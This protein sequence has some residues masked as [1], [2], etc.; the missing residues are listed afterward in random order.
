M[1][2]IAVERFGLFKPDGGMREVGAEAK[3]SF[4]QVTTPPA[5]APH[6][7]SGGQAVPVRVA[8][9]TQ[10]ARQIVFAAIFPCA[11][12]AVLVGALL[13]LRRLRLARV[14]TAT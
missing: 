6:V 12:V 13:G 8:E 14:R 11:L 9:P 7:V 1:P 2:G 3:T 4:G 5:T 10:F